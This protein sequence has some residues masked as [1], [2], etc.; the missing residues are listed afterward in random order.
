M[1]VVYKNAQGIVVNG[2]LRKAILV[3][4]TCRELIDSNA[5]FNINAIFPGVISAFSRHLA[6]LSHQFNYSDM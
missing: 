6:A 5:C 4:G 2:N 1:R 3:F